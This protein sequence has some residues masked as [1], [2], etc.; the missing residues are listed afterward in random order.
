LAA[1]LLPAPLYHSGLE[2][3][4]AA[5]LEAAMDIATPNLPSRDFEVTSRFFAA[6]G[7]AETWRD[8]DW[9]I[10]RR[11]EV[12]LEFFLFRGLDPA[13]SY[14]GSCLRLDDLDTF[15][16]ACLA[17]GI[18]E[19]TSGWPRLRPPAVQHWGGRMG[20]LVDPDCTANPPSR[21]RAIGSRK[22]PG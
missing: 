7:F 13:T 21:P 22:I 16:A 1:P 17:A 6:L 11:G 14:A 3:Q 12:Q 9:M 18:E 8:A 19:K 4:G 10:L 15:Y 5:A 2:A 20:F